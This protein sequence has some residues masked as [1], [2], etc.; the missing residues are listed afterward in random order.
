MTCRLEYDIRV[1]RSLPASVAAFAG[2]AVWLSVLCLAM[3]CLAIVPRASAQAHGAPASVTSEGF[4]GHAINGTAPSVTSFGSHGSA[5]FGT[6]FHESTP[7][8]H[9][10]FSGSLPGPGSG[11]NDHAH[12]HHRDDGY[13]AAN[14]VA[15]P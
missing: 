1:Q 7:N 10:R 12:R 8:S 15:V 3:L 14:W 13:G 2:L 5:S 11:T 9:G 4:G 6:G